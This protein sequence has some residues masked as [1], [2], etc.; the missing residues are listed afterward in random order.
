MPVLKFRDMYLLVYQGSFKPESDNVIK[1]TVQGQS[2]F[3]YMG[4]F[5]VR[6]REN[7]LSIRNTVMISGCEFP[8]GYGELYTEPEFRFIPDRGDDFPSLG[9][10]IPD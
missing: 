4:L 7:F 8:A 9:P 5:P 1:L 2:L 6:D 10:V 3:P